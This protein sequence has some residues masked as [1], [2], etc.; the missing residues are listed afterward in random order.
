MVEASS[1]KDNYIPE[2][3]ETITARPF[4]REFRNSWGSRTGRGDTGVGHF[5]CWARLQSMSCWNK[6]IMEVL[7]EIQLAASVEHV[8]DIKEIAPIPVMGQPGVGIER[9]SRGGWFPYL[10]ANKLKTMLGCRPP[11]TAEPVK[12]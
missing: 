8:T 9:Q 4:V 12:G 11:E 2:T 1:S 6:P 5:K 7:T 10:P 3:S